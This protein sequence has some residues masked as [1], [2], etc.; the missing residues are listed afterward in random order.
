MRPLKLFICAAEPS[1][2]HLASLL[3]RR[4]RSIAAVEARGLCGPKMQEAGVEGVARYE[5][6]TA[7]GLAE[8]LPLVP[9][10]L[11]T[12]RRLTHAIHAWRPDVLVTVDAPSLLLRLSRRIHGIPRVHCVAPQVWAWR[13]GRADRMHHATDR[14]LCLFPFE[15][16]WFAR[17]EVKCTYVGHPDIGRIQPDVLPTGPPTVAL[18]PGSRVANIRRNAEVFLRIAQSIQSRR[19]DVRFVVPAATGVGASEL[20]RFPGTIVSG[21]EDCYA[22]AALTAP[23]TATLHWFAKGVPMSV[24]YKANP[25]SWHLGR[26]LMNPLPAVALPNYLAPDVRIGE[27]LQHIDHA[28]VATEVCELLGEEGARQ[29]SVMLNARSTLRGAGATSFA[30]AQILRAARGEP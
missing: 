20:A 17:S 2:D 27:H 30:A 12:I 6:L 21:I 28:K 5:G 15:A 14:L 8:A 7:I 13:P 18:C 3:V 29:R 24:I 1:G 25:I 4:L 10:A 26:R 19:P 11:H 22:N 9:R 16:Q 23:G